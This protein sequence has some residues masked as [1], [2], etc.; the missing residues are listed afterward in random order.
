MSGL[1]EAETLDRLANELGV[2]AVDDPSL[3]ALGL[4]GLE[5]RV[6]SWAELAY[7]H[8]RLL[9]SLQ[10]LEPGASER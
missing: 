10:G 1:S 6:Y 4:T 5:G 2:L 8:V 7:A 9:K 3:V